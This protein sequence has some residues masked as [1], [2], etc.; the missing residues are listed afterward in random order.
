MANLKYKKFNWLLSRYQEKI[1]SELKKFFNKKIKETSKVSFYNARDIR[2]LR[3]YVL[4]G[5]KRL[6]P[7]LVIIGY[8]LAGG[9]NKKEILKTSLAIELIHNFLLIHD[10]IVDRDDFRRGKPSLHCLYQKMFKNC[11]LGISL[12]MV[13]G[14]IANILKYAILTN[15]NSQLEMGLE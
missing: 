3:D 11:H 1:N 14:D 5:G 12:I 15:S 13:N 6:R 2:L 4:R 7:I 9:K 8:F 10:D